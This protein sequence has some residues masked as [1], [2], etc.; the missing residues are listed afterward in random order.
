VIAIDIDV[1]AAS[2]AL[3][4][5]D[6]HYADAIT[7]VQADVCD[8]ALPERVRGLIGDDP[9]CMVVEDSA[10]TYE[11]TRAALDGFAR[12]V[13]SEGFFIVQ[14]GCVDIESMRVD[15]SWPR[16]VLPAL[17]DW[18]ATPAGNEFVVRRDLE[19]Y[20]LS[21]HPQGFLQK[22]PR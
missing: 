10:H 17:A 16:G 18:L 4:A 22:V 15:P 8:P 21:C 20:G 9:C 19:M 13:A 14:D 3:A 7:L 2:E 12:F 1:S 6:P 5:A 11:T